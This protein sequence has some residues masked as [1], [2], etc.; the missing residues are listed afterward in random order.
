MMPAL[1]IKT[2][3]RSDLER[4]SC[5]ADFTDARLER[6]HSRKVSFTD[7]EACW[8]REITS[9]ARFWLRPLKKMC[10]GFWAAMNDIADAPSPVVPYLELALSSRSMGCYKNTYHQ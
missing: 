5:A 8:T 1:H 2:S 3:R 9:D 6:S 4:N 10:A 7:G